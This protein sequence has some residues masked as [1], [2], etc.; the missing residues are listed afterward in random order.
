MTGALFGPSPFGRGANREAARG[1]GRVETARLCHPLPSHFR[2]YGAPSL[3][4]RE[5]ER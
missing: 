5:R 2:A 3:S 1:E 4:Q